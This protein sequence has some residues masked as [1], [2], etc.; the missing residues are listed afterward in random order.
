[1]GCGAWHYIETGFSVSQ[2]VL[3]RPWMVPVLWAIIVT[4]GFA[5]VLATLSWPFVDLYNNF[6]KAS[7]FSWSDTII[8]AFAG[9]P[10]SPQTRCR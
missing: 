4:I 8:S 6:Y 5:A 7:A 1:M 9:S 10:Y 3:I 2:R